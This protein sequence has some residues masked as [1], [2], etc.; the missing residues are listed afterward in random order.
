MPRIS[1]SSDALVA[2]LAVACVA[3]TSQPSEAGTWSRPIGAWSLPVRVLGFRRCGFRRDGQM[4]ALTHSKASG[5]PRAESRGDGRPHIGASI[6]QYIGDARGHCEGDTLVVETTNFTNKTAVNGAPHSE[7]LK[8][9]EWF[10]RIDPQMIDYRFRV[11]RRARL[12]EASCRGQGEGI[13]DPAPDDRDGGLLGRAGRR[14]SAC[15][16]DRV[17]VRCS[18]SDRD[19]LFP[20]NRVAGGGPAC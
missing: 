7:K 12:R 14:P 6:K 8:L 10:T 11:E 13:A 3:L 2:V 20:C 19:S 15:A 18:L 5:S 4:P 9:T 17:Q 16:G 1:K